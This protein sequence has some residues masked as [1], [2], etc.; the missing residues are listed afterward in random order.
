M[1]D[2]LMHLSRRGMTISNRS[3]MRAVVDLLVAASFLV[4]GCNPKPREAPPMVARVGDK[5]ITVDDLK[6]K[7]A[8]HKKSPVMAKR[9]ARPEH[10]RALLNDMIRDAA[11]EQEARR[12]GYDHDP[13]VLREM[14]NRMFQ[15]EVDHKIST[16][17]ITDA[18]IEAYY[19]QHLNDYARPERVHAGQIVVK[20]KA[21][22]NLVAHQAKQLKPN[23]LD[24][25]RQLV[26][27]YSED[28]QTREKG[29]EIG[30]IERE[31]TK[32]AK[33]VIDTAFK[34]PVGAVSDP[35][36]VSNGFVI[37]QIQQYQKGFRSTPEAIMV[38]KPSI[39]NRITQERRLQKRSQLIAEILKQTRVEIIEDQLAAID[40]T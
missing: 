7:L 34:L 23:D 40:G 30:P 37:L 38:L 6:E 12:K 27:Q 16:E 9:Y 11:L 15:E 32:V 2:E 21:K 29:G 14:V 35:I 26:S 19:Q 36:P 10:R 1:D 20:D 28:S 3:P 5:T 18:D 39:R 17:M 22:A 24:G 8:I 25:F 31:S 4:V 33:E 13:L